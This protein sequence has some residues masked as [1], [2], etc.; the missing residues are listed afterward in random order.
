MIDKSQI[1]PLILRSTPS[2][3]N[4]FDQESF[5]DVG[6][7]YMIAANYGRHLLRLCQTGETKIFP[8]L[9][10]TIEQLIVEGD[11]YVSEFAVIGILEGIVLTWRDENI[12][13]KYLTQHLLPT[14]LAYWESI[15]KFWNGE[16]AYIGADIKS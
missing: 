8:A 3:Q 10:Q 9:S 1:W 16:I 6:L 11:V 14:S 15:A 2:F 7:D 13:T 5:A 4:E 12:D